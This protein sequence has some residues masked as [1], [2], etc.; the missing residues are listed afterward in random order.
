MIDAIMKSR[1]LLALTLLAPV[2]LVAACSPSDEQPLPDIQYQ[3]IDLLTV[4]QVDADE[5]QSAVDSLGAS[6]E[7]DEEFVPGMAYQFQLDNEVVY[8]NF[9]ATE[10]CDVSFTPEGAEID[11]SAAVESIHLI[12]DNLAEDC[13]FLEG[14]PEQLFYKVSSSEDLELANE[15]RI[16]ISTDDPNEGVLNLLPLYP[17]DELIL[18]DNTPFYLQEIGPGNPSERM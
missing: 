16:G 2:A 18:Y 17:G 8:F 11:E 14:A 13:E 12:I 3:P 1:K 6:Y 9:P 7:N 5:Y 4:E 15:V 10:D